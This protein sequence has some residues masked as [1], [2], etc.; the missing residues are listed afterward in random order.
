MGVVAE[1]AVRSFVTLVQGEVGRQRTASADTRRGG[2]GV[3]P[4]W[5]MSQAQIDAE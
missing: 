2:Q 1:Q 5:R 3:D 4:S